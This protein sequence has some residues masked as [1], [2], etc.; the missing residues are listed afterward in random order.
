MLR[1]T[2]SNQIQLRCLA[3]QFFCLGFIVLR[4]LLSLFYFKSVFNSTLD[5]I[6]GHVYLKNCNAAKKQTCCVCVNP[7]WSVDIIN[8]YS[9]PAVL[10]HSVELIIRL[11]CAVTQQFILF[12]DAV[13]QVQGNIYFQTVLFHSLLLIKKPFL[14]KCLLCAGEDRRRPL[15]RTTTGITVKSFCTSLTLVVIK[16]NPRQTATLYGTYC[17]KLELHFTLW[18]PSEL[19]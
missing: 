10:T 6:I 9:A 14:F 17:P 8:S 13:W 16:W 7:Q 1:A 19:I 3:L 5:F 12:S 15:W 18:Q 4:G 11:L 2:G